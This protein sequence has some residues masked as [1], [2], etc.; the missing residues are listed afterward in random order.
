MP[1]TANWI[2]LSHRG[3]WSYSDSVKIYIFGTAMAED[4]KLNDLAQE[5]DSYLAAA[6]RRRPY[7]YKPLV[8]KPEFKNIPGVSDAD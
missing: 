6:A 4:Y 3:K 2:K 1:V 8:L 5:F 7:A